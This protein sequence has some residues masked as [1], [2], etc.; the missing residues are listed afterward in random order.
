MLARF[1]FAPLA[2]IG[3]ALAVPA[4][5]AASAYNTAVMS[6]SPTLYWQ[7]DETSGPTAENAATSGTVGDGA[8]TGASVLGTPGAFSLSPFGATLQGPSAITTAVP[9]G[10]RA[11]ELWVK[12]AAAGSGTFLTYGDAFK[13][14]YNAKRKLTLSVGGA[15]RRTRASACRSTAGRSSMCRSTREPAR[16]PRCSPTAAPGA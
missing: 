15:P 16:T 3:C 10:A 14:G 9:G 5:A 13:L 6:D 4:T 7:L 11:V 12:P 8:V 1:K 2:A